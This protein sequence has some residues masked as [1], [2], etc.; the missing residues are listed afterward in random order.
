M[1]DTA[2]ALRKEGTQ[3]SGIR[4]ALL[5]GVAAFCGGRWRM[6]RAEAGRRPPNEETGGPTRRAGALALCS[7][8]ASIPSAWALPQCPLQMGSH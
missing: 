4:S 5:H 7:T 3:G 8:P 2:P 1:A 6:L